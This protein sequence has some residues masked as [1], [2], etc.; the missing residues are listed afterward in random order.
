MGDGSGRSEF[1]SWMMGDVICVMVDGKL[2]LV[3]GSQMEE[4]IKETI[5][6]L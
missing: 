5:I 3:V 6:N 2:K 1:G 4:D